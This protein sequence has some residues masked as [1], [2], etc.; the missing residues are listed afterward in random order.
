MNV[1]SNSPIDLAE[2]VSYKI[3]K[4]G[5]GKEIDIGSIEPLRAEPRR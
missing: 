1:G 2:W 3:T 4:D 5:C